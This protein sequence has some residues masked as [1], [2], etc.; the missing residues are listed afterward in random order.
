MEAPGSVDSG[1]VG[2]QRVLWD[3][4]SGIPHT[5]PLGASVTLPPTPTTVECLTG[6]VRQVGP[7]CAARLQQQPH[8]DLSTGDG[9]GRRPSLCP[10]SLAIVPNGSPVL[11]ESPMCWPPGCVSFLFLHTWDVCGCMR[12][13]SGQTRETALQLQA[14]RGVVQGTLGSSVE[15]QTVPVGRTRC[16]WVRTGV[17]KRD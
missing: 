1:P 17:R 16:L 2:S 14:E 5:S 3:Q 15:K 4:A 13:G 8:N 12:L 10:A 7:G 6:V 11:P 9:G